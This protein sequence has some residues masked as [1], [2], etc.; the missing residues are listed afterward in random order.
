MDGK[1]ASTCHH[2]LWLS[3]V[4]VNRRDLIRILPPCILDKFFRRLLLENTVKQSTGVCKSSA[5]IA[6][7]SIMLK[8]SLTVASIL[9]LG[10]KVASSLSE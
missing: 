8:M 4:D 7:N 10:M 9:A 5:A 6:M 1:A 2:R 3:Y